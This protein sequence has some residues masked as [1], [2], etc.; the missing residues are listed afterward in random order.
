MK[1]G[2][3]VKHKL[4]G[5]SGEIVDIINRDTC[6][7]VDFGDGNLREVNPNEFSVLLYFH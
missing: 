5:I 6:I 7:V 1:T 3:F 2:D 4:S